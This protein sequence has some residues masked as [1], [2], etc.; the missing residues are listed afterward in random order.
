MGWAGPSVAFRCNMPRSAINMGV[1]HFPPSHVP[2]ANVKA[3]DS[4]F[5]PSKPDFQ[6][7]S[8]S[9]KLKPPLPGDNAPHT[10]HSDSD[11]RFDGGVVSSS[12]A[13]S[14]VGL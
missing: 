1:P 9:S 12:C 11:L 13:T 2:S 5:N 3:D 6:E 10:H 4:S 8:F 7:I 14:E